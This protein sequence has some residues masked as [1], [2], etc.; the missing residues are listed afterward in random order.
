MTGAVVTG[1]TARGTILG[2]YTDAAI[3]ANLHGFVQAKRGDVRPLLLVTPQDI[4][5]G[6]AITGWVR[7]SHLLGLRRL[8]TM[9]VPCT[10]SSFPGPALAASLTPITEALA[11]ND[12]A[13]W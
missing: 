11:P 7:A 10:A 6:E 4:N 5:A 8:S 12:A 2:I 9:R 3:P 1:L 13:W